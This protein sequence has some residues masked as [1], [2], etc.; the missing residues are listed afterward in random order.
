MP[1]NPGALTTLAERLVHV[2]VGLAWHYK[3]YAG[4]QSAEDRER[5][6]FAK[7]AA[8]LMTETESRYSLPVAERVGLSAEEGPSRRAPESGAE[9]RNR[10]GARF[11]PMLL[12]GALVAT[13]SA[14]AGHDWQR[15]SYETPQGSPHIELMGA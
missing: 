15:T 3:R 5:Y 10:G 7:E 11:G 1:R 6:S 4:E 9:R 8:K 2:K 12:A 14:C 13:L